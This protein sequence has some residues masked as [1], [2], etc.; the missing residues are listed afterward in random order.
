MKVLLITEE[1]AKQNKGHRNDCN[2]FD[3]GVTIDGRFVCSTN[4]PGEFPELFENTSFSEIEVQI[5]DFPV[6][7]VE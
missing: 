7:Y 6:V 4:A 5:E 2:V 1:F 3:Y